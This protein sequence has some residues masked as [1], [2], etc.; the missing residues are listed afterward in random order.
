MGLIEKRA[1]RAEALVARV[2]ARPA[3]LLGRRAFL[4]ARCRAAVFLPA[5]ERPLRFR[6]LDGL[7]QFR[8]L[9]LPPEADR[10]TGASR[11]APDEACKAQEDG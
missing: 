4:P 9:V 8:Y 1:C 3:T 7:D 6:L 10:L 5:R 2:S 11:A